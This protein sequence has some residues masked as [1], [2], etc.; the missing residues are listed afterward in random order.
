MQEGA[1]EMGWIHR[2][3][4]RAVPWRE[5]ILDW[6]EREVVVCVEV[7]GARSYKWRE[8]DDEVSAR[9]RAPALPPTPCGA[10]VVALAA[11]VEGGGGM[12]APSREGEKR[13]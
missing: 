7:G 11:R 8:L 10:T 12:V 4:K 9:I 13:R 2:P 3:R 5:R 6:R 1:G